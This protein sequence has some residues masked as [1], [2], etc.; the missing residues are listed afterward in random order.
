MSH[1]GIVL[2]N[3]VCFSL[4]FLVVNMLWLSDI[5]GLEGD[6]Y[7]FLPTHLYKKTKMNFVSCVVVSAILIVTNNWWCVPALIYKFLY[8]VAHVGR[9]EE[10]KMNEQIES[11]IDITIHKILFEEDGNFKYKGCGNAHTHGMEKYKCFNLCLAVELDDQKTRDILN[12]VAE[13]CAHNDKNIYSHL[14]DGVHY[15][16]DENGENIFKFKLK[17][18]LC[19][20]ELC[21][22]IV[23]PDENGMFPEDEKCLE[24]Y[25]Y[26]TLDREHDIK[27]ITNDIINNPNIYVPKELI[28]FYK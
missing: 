21:L 12:T 13:L 26:Q 10:K 22:L 2:V 14:F 24:P 15:V 27:D 1:T 6:S 11:N 28:N 7:Y 9:K 19:Y 20:D 16:D 3:Y 8:W 17:P 25:C 5:I 18:A 23:L 4:A